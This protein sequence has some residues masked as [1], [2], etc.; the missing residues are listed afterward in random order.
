MNK[1]MTKFLAS[2]TAAATMSS[3]FLTPL[4]DISTTLGIRTIEASADDTI[5][6]GDYQYYV[7]DDGAVIT[8][9]MGTAE[10]VSIPAEIDGNKVYAIGDNAFLYNENITSV[11]LHTGIKEVGES[12]FWHCSNLVSISLNEGLESIDENAFTGT[13]I[14]EVTL[15]STLKTADSPFENSSV[16]KAAFADGTES[17]PSFT[18]KGCNTLKKVTFP[19][20]ITNIGNYAFCDCSSLTEIDLHEG[21][22]SLGSYAFRG[23]GITEVTLPSTLKTADYPF[24]NSSVEKAVFADGAESVPNLI[25]RYCD[26]LKEVTLPNTITNIG[27]EAFKYCSSLT[28]IILHEGIESIDKNAFLKTGI[29]EVTLPSTL[30]TADFPFEHCSVTKAVFADGIKVIPTG[31]FQKCD[32]LKEVTLPESVTEIG[33]HAFEQCSS[34]T[35]ID[36]H[37]GIEVLDYY[38]FSGTGLTEITIPSTLKTTLLPFDNSSVTKA[39]FADGIKTI[40]LSVFQNC[41]N[42]KEVTIPESVTEIESHAFES[43]SALN[44]IVLPSKLKSICVDCFSFSGLKSIVIPDEVTTLQFDAFQCC[45]KLKTAT[46]GRSVKNIDETTFIDCSALEKVIFTSPKLNL[47]NYAFKNCRS[48]KEVDHSNTELTFD[49]KTFEKCYALKD[50]DLIYLKRPTSTMTINTENAAVNGIVDFTVE[51]EALAGHYSDDTDFTIILTVPAGVTVLPDTFKTDSGAIN[52]DTASSIKIPFSSPSGK[53]TFSAMAANPGTYDIDADLIFDDAE[54]EIGVRVEPIHS[55][56]FTADVFSLSAPSIVNDFKTGVSGTGPKGKTIEIYVNGELAVNTTANIKTGKF[57]VPLELPKGENGTEYVIKAKCGDAVTSD[58]IVTYSKE[59]PA[60]KSVKLGINGNEAVNDIT[61]VFTKCTSPVMYLK[62]DKEFS[63]ALDITNSKNTEK[64]FITST[65]GDKIA[66]I[67]AEYD[68]KSGLWVAKG[69]FDGKK[70]YVPGTL[71]VVVLSTTKY[72]S[73]TAAKLNI[74]YSDGYF[75]RPGSIRFAIDPSGIV[76]EGAPSNPVSGAEVTVYYMDE[77]GDAVVWDGTDYDQQNPLLTDDYG[78]YAWDVPEG[79]WKVVCKAEGFDTMES[80]WLDVPPAQT[81][82]NFSLVSKTAPEVKD[83]SFDGDSISLKF[84]KYMLPD[85]VNTSNVLI[86]AGTDIEI[87]PNFHSSSEEVTDEFTISGDFT[88][89]TNVKLSVSEGCL[90]YA[91]TPVVPYEQ[92]IHIN[93]DEENTTTTTTTTKST[94]TTTSA[95]TTTTTTAKSTT[96][97]TSAATTTT[98]TAKSTTTTTSAAPITT[99]TT[100]EVDVTTTAPVTTIGTLGD[101]NFNGII[102][103]VDASYLLTLY[104][105]TS[106]N[107]KTATAEEIAVGDVDKNGIIDGR[108]ATIVLTYYAYISTTTENILPLEEFIKNRPE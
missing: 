101:I 57:D 82:I 36:L 86:N 39:V 92:S 20:T 52:I 14:T 87:T 41:K 51:F 47:G 90:S 50:M 103:G 62:P 42:L 81:G 22:E 15:P 31:V 58:C 85:T 73:I 34:L 12:A 78:A 71:N 21:I 32:T 35:K 19:K 9:Y 61:D 72:N 29:T 100:N 44:E 95:A 37:E 43:C 74:D 67:E 60:I 68:E 89:V 8:D 40:P 70:N 106:T 94:T 46:I 104:A 83:I 4:A 54:N 17:V 80:E 18:F 38:A 65:K 63:F 23:S 33:A 2:L 64:V 79:E 7:T 59:E 98:T 13:G 26:T 53:L 88:D 28:K 55:V 3:V 27:S 16:E 97:T 69:F 105:E 1:K 76:Y 93:D 24:E 49:K 108:D 96:T 48:L 66:K 11:I 6:S 84:S 5:T 99:T 25:F 91:D 45:K 75:S 30:K 102:D 77:N 10:K 107:K 56:R